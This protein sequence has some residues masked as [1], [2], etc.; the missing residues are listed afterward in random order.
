MKISRKLTEK[1]KNEWKGPV[2]YVAHHAVLRP[3]KNTPIRIVLNSSTSVKGHMLNDYWFKGPDLLNNLFG[4]VFRFREN[5]VTVCGDITKMY[6]MVAI[7][8][9]DQHVHRFLWRGY[10]TER[11]PDIYVKTVLTFGD[12]LAPTMMITAM[13]KTANR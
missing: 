5:T 2:H 10:K 13:R 3:E 7:R 1:E 6:H 8:T 12:R 11:E 9:V 4:V